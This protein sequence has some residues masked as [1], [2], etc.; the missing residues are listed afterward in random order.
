MFHYLTEVGIPYSRLYD[1]GTYCGGKFVD[2]QNV[3]RSF[4]NDPADPVSYDFTFTD[5]LITA[6]IKNNIEPFFRLGTTIENYARI[7][8]YYI[9]PPID[10]FK[11]AKICE[12]IIRH[13]TKAGRMVSIT[14]SPIGKSGTSRTTILT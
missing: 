6:L 10:N 13:Y 7:K 1:V 2:I 5:L 11:W 4:D 14:R 12:G 8:A 3:F 9:Y